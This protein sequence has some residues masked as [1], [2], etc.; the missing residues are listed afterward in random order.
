MSVPRLVIAEMWKRALRLS[1]IVMVANLVLSIP[2]LF[3]AYSETIGRLYCLF[4]LLQSPALGLMIL[5]GIDCGNLPAIFILTFIWG[6]YAFFLSL[7]WQ[8]FRTIL[9]KRKSDRPVA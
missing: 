7:L 5:L 3:D 2:F 1:L 4:A 6:L 8:V 9:G